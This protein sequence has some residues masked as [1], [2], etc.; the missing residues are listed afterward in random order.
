MTSTVPHRSPITPQEQAQLDELYEAFDAAHMTPAVDP[1]RR[2]DADQPAPGRGA[3]AVALVDAAAAGRTQRAS[4]CPVGRGGERRAIALANPGPA[5]HGRTPPRRCGPRSSTSARA[6]RR[7][8]TGTRRPRSA[9]SSRARACG[10]TSRATR[11]RCAA[12]TC[13]SPR[14]CTSTSTTTPPTSRWP[15]STGWTS[16]WSARSTPG[17]FEFGPDELRTRQTPAVSRN[18]RL[19]GHPGPDA[20]SAR[21][22]PRPRR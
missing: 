17:F 10:P 20:R 4:W 2:T 21:R 5:R 19:W 1:A 11:S 14:A 6:R 16:R 9:S 3:D 12:A 22:A 8:R 7:P 15:G 13:C 18:E